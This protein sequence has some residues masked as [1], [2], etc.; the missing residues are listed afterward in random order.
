AHFF[1]PLSSSGRS[2]IIFALHPCWSGTAV[3]L[4]TTPSLAGQPFS[5]SGSQISG[6]LFRLRF[7]CSVSAGGAF[8]NP[9]SIGIK[10]CRE[11]SRFFC[12]PLQF[13]FPVCSLNL[14]RGN[15]TT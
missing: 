10:K 13:L 7:I 4:C 15:G 3:G 6:S 12:R 2:A 8:G 5:N 9:A 11:K 1:Q 14:R